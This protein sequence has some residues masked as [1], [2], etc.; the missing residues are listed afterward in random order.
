MKKCIISTIMVIMMLTLQMGMC[1]AYPPTQS[2]TIGGYFAQGSS[3]ANLYSATGSTS[4]T[5]TG[6]VAV[7]S[8]YYSVNI[9]T[10]ST[11][12]DSKSRSDAG[13]NKAVS[14]SFTAE[15]N[16]KTVRIESR[17]EVHGGGQTWIANTEDY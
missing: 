3:A 4:Y 10:L 17:H 1:Y 12:S 7:W 9:Y 8:T 11:N 5:G 16:W 15:D 2:A 13:S 14:V 6:S